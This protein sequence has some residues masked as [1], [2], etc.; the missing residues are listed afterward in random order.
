MRAASHT[1]TFMSK[2]FLIS[3]CCSICQ[4]SV[5]L[6]KLQ[7]CL[8]DEDHNTGRHVECMHDSHN[9]VGDVIYS[10]SINSDLFSTSGSFQAGLQ[11]CFRAAVLCALNL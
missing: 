7:K 4:L 3:T 5:N 11:I 2:L 8:L 9:P 1:L 10:L 6:H